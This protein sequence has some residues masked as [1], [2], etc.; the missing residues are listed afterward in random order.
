MLDFWGGRQTRSG[1]GNGSINL[2]AR[3]PDRTKA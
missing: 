3:R 1:D 2:L